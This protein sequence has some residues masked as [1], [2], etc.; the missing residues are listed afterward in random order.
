MKFG[1]IWSKE[2]FKDTSKL[3]LA[4]FFFTIA[5]IKKEGTAY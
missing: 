3:R 2:Y 1:A 5:Y 4:Q